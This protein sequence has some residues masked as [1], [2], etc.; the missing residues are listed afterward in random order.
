MKAAT[1]LGVHQ[2]FMTEYEIAAANYPA[3]KAAGVIGL[4]RKYDLK[5]KG[6]ENTSADE[7]ELLRELIYKILH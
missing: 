6:I 4:L 1:V 2:F 7:G 3:S 5:S